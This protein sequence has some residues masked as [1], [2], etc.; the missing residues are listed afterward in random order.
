MTSMKQ[1]KAYNSDLT[2]AQWVRVRKLIPQ[3]K[4]GG[5]PREI[6]IREILHAIFLPG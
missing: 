3:A 1:R 2:Q 6:C 5:H 4:S